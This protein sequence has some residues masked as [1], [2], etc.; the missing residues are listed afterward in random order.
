MTIGHYEA[1]NIYA[2]AIMSVIRS[3]GDATNGPLVASRIINTSYSG[4]QGKMWINSN[5][6]RDKDYNIKAFSE[7]THEFEVDK[8]RCCVST[9]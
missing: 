4:P 5:R 2:N 7:A 9:L 6:Q 1:I 8:S 3:G